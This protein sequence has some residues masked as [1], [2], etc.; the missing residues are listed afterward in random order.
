MRNP[1]KSAQVQSDERSP[2]SPTRKLLDVLSYAVTS[3]ANK[4]DIK[5]ILA[6]ESDAPCNALTKIITRG[7]PAHTPARIAHRV[8][9]I[10]FIL[11]GT[12]YDP[13]DVQRFNGKALHWILPLNNGYMLTLDDIGDILAWWRLLRLASLEHYKGGVYYYGHQT[14]GP[15]PAGDQTDTSKNAVLTA[16]LKGL[17]AIGQ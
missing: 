12:L 14:H 3:K 5:A 2:L 17:L 7:R 16:D 15:V 6:G 10:P 4:E 9:H 13:Q 1:A 11:N 8:P